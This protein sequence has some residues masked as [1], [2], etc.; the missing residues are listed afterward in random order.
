[1]PKFDAG[2]VVESLEW[3]FTKAGVKA[4]GITPEPTD[5]TIGRFM[6]GLKKLYEEAQ[7]DMTIELGDDATPE[8]M[9]EAMSSL[10]GDSFVKFMADVAGLFADLCGGKPSKEQL[11][12]LPMRVRAHFYAWIQGEVVNPEVGPG[13]GTAVVRSLPTA[14]AG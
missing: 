4:K 8:Q 9:L 2:E 6:D 11:L 5:A 3:D 12:A 14:A 10:T 7:K 13:G 1:M